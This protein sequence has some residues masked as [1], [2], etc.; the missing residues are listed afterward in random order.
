MRSDERMKESKITVII[1]TR[2]RCDVLQKTLATVTNQN[3]PNLEII[4]S[5]N[6]SGD[7]TEEVVKGARDSRVRYVNTGRR[8]SMAKNWEFALSHV[9]SG[10]VTIIGDDDGLLPES[11]RKVADIIEGTE[12][13]AIRSNVCTY[14]WP[15]LLGKDFGRL[16]VP[17]QSGYEIRNSRGWLQKVLDGDA[18]YP[19]LPM[20]YYGG[21]VDIAVL[22]EIKDKTGSIYS[23]CIPDVYSAVSIASTIDRYMFH[24]EPLCINGASSHSTGTSQFSSNPTKPSSPALMFA[25]ESNIPFHH[26]LPLCDD[27]SYPPSLQAMVYESYLQSE[28]LRPPSSENLHARM[29]RVILATSTR[30]DS[31]IEDWGRIF[32]SKHGLDFAAIYAGARYA[33]FWH[34]ANAIPRRVVAATNAFSI[35][36][37]QFPISDIYEAS[38]A[39]GAIRNAGVT[40]LR[41]VVRL[42][43]RSMERIGGVAGNR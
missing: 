17:L 8:V 34:K 41:N 14:V 29:L 18:G 13:R 33:K 7:G 38:I 15:A 35:G 21:F 12:V 10:W 42:V 28:S 26:D 1:P 3:Y 16:T 40:R 19:Q 36:S 30:N 11:V 25:S 20:L 6:F 43:G 5:D 39:A 4:V 2:A 37:P 27:G 22:R 23:S 31:R 24:R 9:D 32:A